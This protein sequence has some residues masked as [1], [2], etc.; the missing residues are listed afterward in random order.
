MRAVIISDPKTG[1]SSIVRMKDD[2]TLVDP[3]PFLDLKEGVNMK[4]FYF[5]NKERYTF[6]PTAYYTSP[7]TEEELLEKLNNPS[8][9]KLIKVFDCEFI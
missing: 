1:F 7:Y 5:Y 3:V 2:Y 8:L 6:S 4:V 9:Q